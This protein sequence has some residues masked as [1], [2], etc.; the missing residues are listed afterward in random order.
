MKLNPPLRIVLR[1]TQVGDL[2][3]GRVSAHEKGP[4]AVRGLPHF[5]AGS[6]HNQAEAVRNFL[7][8]ISSFARNQSSSFVTVLA[9]SFLVE[10]VGAFADLVF[11]FES[12]GSLISVAGVSSGDLDS[13]GKLL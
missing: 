8:V 12:C 1:Q 5:L 11:E 6:V 7:I 10:F 9:A 13:W 3:D 4:G 2:N